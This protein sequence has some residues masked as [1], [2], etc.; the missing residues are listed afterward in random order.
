MAFEVE[1]DRIYC[2]Q[3]K[4]IAEVQRIE[5]RPTRLTFAE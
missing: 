4:S 5:F 3:R 1:D 2:S